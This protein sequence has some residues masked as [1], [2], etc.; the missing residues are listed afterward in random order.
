MRN[1]PAKISTNSKLLKTN[2]QELGQRLRDR[3]KE[4][5]VNSTDA[6]EASEISRVTL[7]RIEKGEPSVTMAAYMSV[8][9]ALGL[10]LDVFDP[11]VV[12]KQNQDVNL[13]KKIR[14][15]NYKQ[16][17]RLAWQVKD[18]TELT[19]E[20]ALNLYERNWR[21][22]DLKAMEPKEKRFLEKLMKAFKRERM[23]V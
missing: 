8:I 23:L 10:K 20:E 12:L 18:T 15:S 2:L 1:M 21:H 4:L 22:V 7:Y 11:Q 13:P 5:K 19:P 14:I 3:R 17:K 9:L 16:L 6:A